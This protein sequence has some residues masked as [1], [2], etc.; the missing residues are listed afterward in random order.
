MKLYLGVSI[1]PAVFSME[2]VSSFSIKL[3]RE[4]NVAFQ[5][6]HGPRT[7]SENAGNVALM[8]ELMNSV[9]ASTYDNLSLLYVL[10]SFSFIS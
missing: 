1:F 4:D 6:A 10:D 3:V 7:P 8:T 9:F 2:L 5:R